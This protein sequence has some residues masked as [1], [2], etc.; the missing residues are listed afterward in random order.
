MNKLYIGVLIGLTFGVSANSYK[1]DPVEVS[2]QVIEGEEAFHL[3]CKP[4]V[5][6]LKLPANWVDS[7]NG[8]GKKLL[9]LAVQNGVD[10]KIIDK[11]FGMAGDFAQQASNELPKNI[12]PKE[13]ISPKFGGK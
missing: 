10:V 1:S 12:T 3:V 9:E 4:K 13:I 2:I 7:C 8:I 5:P 11:V 6:M